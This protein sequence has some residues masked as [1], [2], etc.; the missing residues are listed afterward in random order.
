MENL[1]KPSKIKLICHLIVVLV[2]LF[3]SLFIGF[4]SSGLNYSFFTTWNMAIVFSINLIVGFIIFYPLTSGAIFIYSSIKNKTY[5][6]KKIIIAIIMILIFNPLT[7]S[8]IINKAILFFTKDK[9]ANEVE[10]LSNEPC[11]LVIMSISEYS[12]VA[13]AGLK[14]GDMI[15]GFDGKEVRTVKELLAL[16]GYHKP[17]DRIILK[18]AK[19]DKTVELVASLDDSNHAVLGVNLVENTYCKN[20]Q[21]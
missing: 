9:I 10:K 3:I 21:K 4:K 18:T 1:L 7:L 6:A 17:G 2:I 8:F 5:D 20:D 14:P 13:E 12:R 15:L 19:G 11:G 16:L